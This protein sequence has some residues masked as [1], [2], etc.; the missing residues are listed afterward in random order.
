MSVA[1]GPETSL[2]R[3]IDSEQRSIKVHKHSNP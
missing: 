3:E 1:E 2:G